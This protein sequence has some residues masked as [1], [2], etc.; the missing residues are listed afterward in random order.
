[1]ACDFDQMT[2]YQLRGNSKLNKLFINDFPNGEIVFEGS[3]KENTVNDEGQ[4]NKKVN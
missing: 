4:V 2:S 1:M 3:E